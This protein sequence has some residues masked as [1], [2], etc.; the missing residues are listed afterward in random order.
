MRPAD[1]Q[2]GAQPAERRPASLILFLAWGLLTLV[3]FLKV[4][5]PLIEASLVCVV[6][7]P[8]AY[9]AD[10]VR[11]TTIKPARFTTGEIVPGGIS[12]VVT[13]AGCALTLVVMGVIFEAVARRFK[14]VF[15]RRRDT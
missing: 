1:R 3:A 7:G 6:L 13:L 15:R 14:R 9:F 10:H 4:T 11:I 8:H 2:Q 12:A 5:V